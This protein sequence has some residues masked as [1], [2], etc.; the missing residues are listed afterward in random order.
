MFRVHVET[1]WMARDRRVFAGMVAWP[2]RAGLAQFSWSGCRVC[3]YH[4]CVRCDLTRINALRQLT[5]C[6]GLTPSEHS[7]GNRV[8]RGG[9]TKAG[10]REPRRVQVEIS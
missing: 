7:S 9:I 2:C 4:R 10:N 1:V 8:V 5:A 6:L 3:S